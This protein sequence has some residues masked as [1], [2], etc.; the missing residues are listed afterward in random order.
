M[1]QSEGKHFT[2]ISTFLDSL[3]AS[4]ATERDIYL[5]DIY[6]L[7]K[8]TKSTSL[9]LLFK[10]KK[11]IKQKNEEKEENKNSLF[12]RKGKKISSNRIKKRIWQASARIK[13][14]ND[15]LSRI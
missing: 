8:K 5:R 3:R 14:Y 12:I 7:A 2:D 11:K 15:A 1:H 4:K 13:N 10:K 9:F 6:I